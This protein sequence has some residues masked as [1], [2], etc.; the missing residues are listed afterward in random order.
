MLGRLQRNS[1]L[2][3][4]EAYQAHDTTII[5]QRQIADLSQ[6]LSQ[7][8]D[9]LKAQGN[10]IL[11]LKERCSTLE[12]CNQDI[13]ARA[14]ASEKMADK[15]QKAVLRVTKGLTEVA[16]STFAPCS[17]IPDSF[18]RGDRRPSVQSNPLAIQ[19]ISAKRPTSS[20][21]STQKPRRSV[22]INDI[23]SIESEKTGSSYG[24]P[25]IPV[26]NNLKSQTLKLSHLN[27]PAASHEQEFDQRTTKGSLQNPTIVQN[28]NSRRVMADGRVLERIKLI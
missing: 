11:Q 17:D 20:R 3:N 24:D 8:M 22:S 7:A 15:L 14:D 1:Q 12:R 19:P 18:T 28:M 16:N 6:V 25:E 13:Q 9:Q 21:S 5:L 26:S 2:I 23:P 27:T 10:E 4:E